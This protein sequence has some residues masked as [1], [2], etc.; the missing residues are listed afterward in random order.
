MECFLYDRDLHQEGVKS[1]VFTGLL[2]TNASEI[3]FIG[4]FFGIKILRDIDVCEINIDI[5]KY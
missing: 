2:R 1:T 5:Q 4:K 3:D